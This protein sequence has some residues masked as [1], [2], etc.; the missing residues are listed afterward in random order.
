MTGIL[1]AAGRRWSIALVLLLAGAAHAAP[2]PTL[3]VGLSE[4]SLV[5]GAIVELA[6]AL[7][8]FVPSH[9]PQFQKLPWTR[10]QRL[11]ENGDI[12]MFVTFPAS[13][14]ASYAHFTRT[15]LLSLDYGHLVYDKLGSKARQIEAATSFADL[16][17]LVFVHQDKVE[18]EMLNVPPY[19]KRY[20][21]NAPMHMFHMTFGRRAGDF[22]IM[23]PEQAEYF[24]RKLGYGR[25]L[26]IRK[27][28]FIP[29]QHVGLHIG[30]R[31][32][33]PGSKALV[34][35]LDTAMQQPGFRQKAKAIT[36]RY[37]RRAP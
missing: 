29:N 13:N 34:D 12:D 26:G 8:Q 36:A 23:Y 20:T 1:R 7:F 32:S 19:I 31:K 37:L 16:K 15:A 2:A 9:Q 21:V 10:A 33:Y 14:R 11:V 17:D 25:Q 24:A 27:V 35:A 3:R 5:N 18:W 28:D 6:Q 22:F 30:I 4:T